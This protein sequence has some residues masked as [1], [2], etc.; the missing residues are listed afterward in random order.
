MRCCRTKKI[1]NVCGTGFL[2][3]DQAGGARLGAA[4]KICKMEGVSGAGYK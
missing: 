4:R 2:G 1:N 3:E